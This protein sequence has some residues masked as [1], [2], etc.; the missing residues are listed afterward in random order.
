MIR[1]SSKDSFILKSFQNLFEQKKL[2]IIDCDAENYF[3]NLEISRIDNEIH[4]LLN[5]K[6]IKLKFQELFTPQ[7]I[8][9]NSRMISEFG[10]EILSFQKYYQWFQEVVPSEFRIQSF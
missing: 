2:F 4:F 1:I 8:Y 10:Y 9:D 7:K 6:I 3:H 5:K